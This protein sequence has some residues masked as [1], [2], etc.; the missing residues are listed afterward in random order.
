[1]A[2]NVNKISKLVRNDTDTPF[3]V[4]VKKISCCTLTKQS[5]NSQSDQKR[6]LSEK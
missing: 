2:L 6:F 5:K 1:M 4:E 3:K